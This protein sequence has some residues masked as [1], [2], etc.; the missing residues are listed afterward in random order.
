MKK[1]N[2]NKQIAKGREHENKEMIKM[3]K[4]K[5][6]KKIYQMLWNLKPKPLLLPAW[7]S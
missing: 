1:N 2:K 7:R 5:Q 3:I 6:T 4:M